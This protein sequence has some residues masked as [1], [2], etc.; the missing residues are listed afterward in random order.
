MIKIILIFLLA[1]G[2]AA[3]GAHQAPERSTRPWWKCCGKERVVPGG[4]LEDVF[5]P[6]H[7]EVRTPKTR[8]AGASRVHVAPLVVGEAPGIL[9]VQPSSASVMLS[10][11]AV[12]V[13]EVLPNSEPYIC[14]P[15]YD[16][17]FDLGYP[18]ELGAVDADI[19]DYEAQVECL[20]RRAA[21]RRAA[22]LDLT[23][24]TTS[25]GNERVIDLILADPAS[26]GSSPALFDYPMGDPRRD[27]AFEIM[28]RYQ[29]G[30]DEGCRVCWT[31][32]QIALH[33]GKVSK[34]FLQELC[35]EVARQEI[36]RDN[37][38]PYNAG[39]LE[40]FEGVLESV[41]PMRIR[42]DLKPIMEKAR[43]VAHGHLRLMDWHSPEPVR[44][45]RTLTRAETT[46]DE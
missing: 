8:S 36:L 29:V 38:R 30:I 4:A 42:D 44:V 33:S 46:M 41:F 26:L 39:F 34:K 6:D 3:D 15:K 17:A 5:E 35:Y 28:R 23:V 18:S 16:P 45:A 37:R 14:L 19:P 20:N 24:V 27:V 22:A 2:S 10:P 13:P 12:V 31:P 7:R 25:R 32:L 21:I 1:L 11:V 43:I 40:A 9:D